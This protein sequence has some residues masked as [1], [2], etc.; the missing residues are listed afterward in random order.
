MKVSCKRPNPRLVG[1]PTDKHVVLGVCVA[2]SSRQ[3]LDFSFSLANER[4][5]SPGRR[6]R[7]SPALPTSPEASPNAR[8]RCGRDGNAEM[9]LFS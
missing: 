6:R 3:S 4:R 1:T 9:R 5:Q 7:S 8:A 2:S